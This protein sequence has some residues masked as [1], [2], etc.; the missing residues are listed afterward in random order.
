MNA[1]NMVTDMKKE[2]DFSQGE[3]GKFFDKDAT[4]QLPV[5]LDEEIMIYMEEVA[6]KR[7]TDISTIVNQFLRSDIQLLEAIK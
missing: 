1:T 6:N 7:K 3:R 2:Y 4:F 5:Y